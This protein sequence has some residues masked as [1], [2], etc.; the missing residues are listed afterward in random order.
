MIAVRYLD[1]IP[2]GTRTRGLL[3]RRQS[4]YPTEL[5]GRVCLCLM[6]CPAGFEPAPPKGTELKSV[7]LDHSAIDTFT[8]NIGYKC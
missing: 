2:Y 5:R 6:V 4:L 3:L 1:L 7:A 8:G